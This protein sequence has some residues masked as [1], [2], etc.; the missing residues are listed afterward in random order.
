MRQRK[1][2]VKTELTYPALK[3]LKTPHWEIGDF[4]LP[5]LDVKDGIRGDNLVCFH[6]FTNIKFTLFR[7]S[8]SNGF[9][10][11]DADAWLEYGDAWS[12]RCENDTVRVEFADQTVNAVPYDT[13]IIGYGG[14]AVN[15]L[16]LWQSEPVRGFDFCAFDSQDYTKASESAVLAEAI[17]NVLYPNDNYEKGLKLRLK[18]QYFFVSASVQDI[19]RRYKA[20]H[21]DD[22]SDF[23]GCYA[24][25]LNDT[26]PTVAIPELIRIFMFKEGMSFKEAFNIA[27]KTCHYTNHTVMSEALEKWDI[28]LF[29]S[30]IPTIYEIILMIDTHLKKY[31]TSIGQSAKQIAEKSV[32]DGERIHM[33]RMAVFGSSHTNGVAALHTQILK[34][35]ALKEWY[36]IFP[37]RFQNKTNGITPRR[38]LGLCNEE[39]SSLITEKIGNTWIT[40]LS[41][42]QKL[43][44][45]VDDRDTINRFMQIK[46]LKKQQLCD[47][48]AKKEGVL[49]SPDFVFDIQ[50]KRLHEYKRQLLNAFSI[51]DLY[52]KI[53]EN[54]LPDLQPTAFIFG[55][56][57]APAYKRAK[58]II[59]YINEVAKLVNSDP[60]TKGKLKV[61]FVQNYN[62]SYAEKLIPAAD[63]SEQISTAGLEASGTGN[64]KFMLNGAVTLGTLDGAN[65][66]IV[67]EAGWE[68]E[69][70]F[71][72][73]VEEIEKIKPDYR[74]K[75]K[76]YYR[77]ERV[78][79]VLN[80]LVDGT[81]NDG[82]TGMFGELFNSLTNGTSWHKPDHYFLLADLES[83]ADTKLRALYDYK[84]KEV[85]AKKC[86]MHIASAGKFSSDRTVAEYANELWKL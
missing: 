20:S 69:Y 34:N 37:E 3:R 59:K 76:I 24:L 9:Q 10:R 51:M 77:N 14:K 18:Q 66:E 48:I 47:Y 68:N 62:V 28:N 83:Y 57:A 2:S 50:V 58:G 33:A 4:A 54:K 40:D 80:T 25:Q 56:K 1:F 60:D 71:G 22:F 11:E 85:F 63:I 49:L 46:K 35:D 12:I 5:V 23:A 44:K 55:A 67:E 75:E 82:D 41:E 8:I 52:F 17:S 6:N 13:P 79:K 27:Q 43:K 29:K 30:V 73:R 26:H 65:V 53:K 21:G 64:M 38:W 70:I 84:N 45:F 31:L 61:I 15:T 72:C 81:F 39:L 7:Q 42:L 74:P 19:I 78:K 86:W 16:R 32:T 36:E